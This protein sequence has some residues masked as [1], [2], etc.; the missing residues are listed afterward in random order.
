[1]KGSIVAGIGIVIALG[2]LT[3]VGVSFFVDDSH[4][5]YAKRPES[6]VDTATIADDTV[7]E[8]V[9]I[10]THVPTP[11]SVKAIYMTSW[12]AGTSS[13]RNHVINLID[14]KEF[15]SIVIDIKDDTGKVSFSLDGF[16]V[17]RYESAENRIPDIRGLIQMLHEKDIYVIGRISVFQDPYLTKQRPDLA[18]KRVSDGEIWKDRKGLA[19]LDQSSQEVWDYIADLA[20][21][22]Y[23]VG[24]D[25]INFDYVRFPSDGNIADIDYGL[26]EGKSR[27]DV[28]EE[29]FSYL[30]AELEGEGMVRSADLFGMVTTNSDDLGI[31]QV[32]ERALPYFDYIA[33]MVYPSH[34][35]HGFSGYGNPNHYPYEII[36]I[37]MS[38]AASRA[39]AI[40][41]PISKLRPWLQDFDYG[42]NY[43][44]AEVQ[45]QIQ[46]VY[47][48]GLNSWMIWDP[49]NKYT[50]GAYATETSD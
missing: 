46:A 35:P 29:F 47:D 17:A 37:S 44:V 2:I 30:A 41:E 3:V 50:P 20:R 22:S 7:L 13:L 23:A 12:V 25:E 16:E 33:P 26:D 5:L 38:R 40:G 49:G 21:A 19:F 43:G 9:F 14:T 6:V 39:A 24:F 48:S 27:A 8:P 10:A 31:G 28:I 32:L 45:E 4:E 42:G 34:Y 1:M 15:N 11:E 36:H 18:V